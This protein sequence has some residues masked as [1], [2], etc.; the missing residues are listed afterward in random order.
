[1]PVGEAGDPLIKKAIRRVVA[2]YVNDC[3]L[4]VCPSQYMMRLLEELGGAQCM[5]IIPTP[6]RLDAF[7]RGE[8]EWVR[9]KHE[10][11]A[12]E[13]VLVYV[14]RFAME[15]CIPFLLRAFRLVLAE[16]SGCKLM[17]VG[18]GPEEKHLRRQVQELGIG[19]EVVF[20]GYVE[21]MQV[22]DYLAAADLFVFASRSEVQPLSLLEA[23]A[24]GLPA[25]A[26]RTAAT[27]DMLTSGVDSVLT[28]SDETAFAAEVVRLLRD[29]AERY[30]LAQQARRTAQRYSIEATTEKLERAYERMRCE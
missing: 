8:G 12:A 28:E 18:S 5:E 2:D 30:A 1:V 7:G 14:G 3:D 11:G 10:L 24:A 4:V 22:P 25:V 21:H 23:L 19:G 16:E 27:E 15:K 20:A 29:D 17:L 13:R 6:V 26:V 9:E